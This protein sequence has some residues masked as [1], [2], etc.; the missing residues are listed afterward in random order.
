MQ[1]ISSR[2]SYLSLLDPSEEKTV[3]KIMRMYM[4]IQYIC[5]I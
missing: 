1:F 5:N 4:L 3:M 2:I